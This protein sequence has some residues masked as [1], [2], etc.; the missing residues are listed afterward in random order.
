MSE[1][2]YRKGNNLD[3]DRAIDLHNASTL[4]ERRPVDD[5]EISR[6]CCATPILSSPRGMEIC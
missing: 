1:I 5:R 2:E 6:A 4:G 3:L